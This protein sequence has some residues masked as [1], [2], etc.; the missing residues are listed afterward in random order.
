MDRPNV[1]QCATYA[2]TMSFVV[3]R[4]IRHLGCTLYSPNKQGSVVGWASFEVIRSTAQYL[5]ESAA[6]EQDH[7]YIELFQQQGNLR[8]RARRRVQPG[9]EEM[10][11]GRRRLMSWKMDKG[12]SCN[13]DEVDASRHPLSQTGM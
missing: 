11:S 2:G 3:K 8:T 9:K 13:I 6:A 7:T 5:A 4:P 10:W 12:L 1:T